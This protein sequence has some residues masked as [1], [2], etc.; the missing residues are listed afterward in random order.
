MHAISYIVAC[1]L[2]FKKKIL[3]KA[4][5]DVFTALSYQWAIKIRRN[6]EGVI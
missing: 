1:L 5:Q 4:N 6:F 3:D 2:F